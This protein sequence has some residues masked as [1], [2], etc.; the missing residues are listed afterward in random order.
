MIGTDLMNLGAAV[1]D[2]RRARRRAALEI[3]MARI[4]GDSADLL[5]YEDVRRKLKARETG[6]EHLEDVPLDAI[7]GSVGRYS[8]FTR[9]FLPRTNSTEH[10][11][12]NV[13][14]A[15]M[16]PT[17]GLPP[18]ELYKV[19]EAYFVVDG[20][21][22]VSV[23]R[24]LESSHIE[25]YVTEVDT[26]VPLSPDDSPDDLI[27]KAEYTDFLRETN[28][29]TLR[30][31]ADLTLTA[32]GKYRLLKEHIDVHR[33]FMG[34]D[35]NRE[36]TYE[37]AVTHWYDTVYLPIVHI[38]RERD[39]LHEFPER[40][41][42]DL[43]L[44]IMEH[45]N[46]LHDALG[47]EVGPEDVATDL[48]EQ[49]S[50]QPKHVVARV[51]RR[52]LDVVTPDEVNVGPVPGTWRHERLARRHDDRLFND[53]LVALNGEDSGWNAFDQA[54]TLAHHE[55]TRV[56]G[57]HVV[58]TERQAESDAVT[59][60]QEEFARRLQEAGIAG[61][62]AVG[63]GTV[64]QQVCER[65]RWAD[66]VILSLAHPLASQPLARLSSGLRTLLRR[67]SRPV[68]LVPAGKPPSNLDRALL[69]YDGSLRAQEALFIGAYM[70]CAWHT[71]L[72]VLT[73]D[74]HKGADD[75]IEQARAY[76][77]DRNVDA[78]TL[79]KSG[80]AGEVILETARERNANLL[81]LGG[82]GASPVIEVILGSTVE[83][84]LQTAEYPMLICH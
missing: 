75:V 43:Y 73:V 48:I 19:G 66:L 80:T 12:A 20:H 57:L 11:W 17:G 54:V 24:E 33:Y 51:S 82:F 21:H 47:W 70:A 40:T 5:S 30:P 44:W 50:M 59:A 18:I 74:E 68:L 38:I 25:A 53:V 3:I 23:A 14:V 45:R 77:E 22:R 63:V 10:R 29:D 34:I 27:V 76:L 41:E 8:D 16:S 2:F 28:L 83:H 67:C 32:P 6:T 78:E 46:A 39:L 13:K 79:L 49:Y 58:P 1:S 31:N 35:Q 61:Q 62:L 56:K 64:T 26:K 37:E 72:T 65:A 36:I 7:V 81:L 84:L 15:T 69:A 71:D 42:T 60:L 52:L 4:S 9:S 55:G